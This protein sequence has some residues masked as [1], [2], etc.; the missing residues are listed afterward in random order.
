[1]EIISSIE[2]MQARANESRRA[3]K[4]IVFV[5]TMG[6]LHEGH[7]SLLREGK[8]HG[9]V[10]VLSIFINPTQFGPE[11]D[12][13]TYPSNL[14]RDIE[15]AR[16]EK[17]A[18]VFTPH[19][20]DLYDKDFQTYIELEKLPN[21]LCGL[22]RPVLFRGAVTVVTKL[23]NIVKPHAAVFGQKD[24]QQL[25][26]IRQMVR[27]LNVAIKIVDS[28]TIREEDGLAMS[29]R[30]T[31]LTPEQRP[32][33]LSLYKSLQQ[34]KTMVENG[35]RN[36]LRIID[37]AARLIGSHVGNHIDYISV[38]DPET[39]ND[40][41]TINRPALMALAV[42]VGKIRLIDNVILNP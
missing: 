37:T 27:D 1:M 20:N 24:F 18:I 34:A 22:S 36:A 42:K 25:A 2:N 31:Y 39:L 8:K 35:E 30:N 41:E 7:L 15:L 5:P 38:C 12:F 3:D 6:F 33:A 19:T 9:D 28:P 40:M 23:F 26:I 10:L 14:D 11:E 17:V 4:K 21:H 32:C 16:K 29:S 13:D